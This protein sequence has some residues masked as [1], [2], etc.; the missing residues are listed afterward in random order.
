VETWRLLFFRGGFEMLDSRDFGILGLLAG[1]AGIVVSIFAYKRLE[2]IG[3]KV[4]MSIKDLSAK[5]TVDIGNA[6]VDKAVQKA[7]NR[8]VGLAVASAANKAARTVAD[9]MESKIRKQ[10][11]AS[12][13][14]IERSVSKEI[15]RQVEN[16]NIDKIKR[17]VTEKAKE[18]V[19]EKLD[20]S[21]DD[22]VDGF[23]ENL[24]T[25]SKI[26]KAIGNSVLKTQDREIVIKLE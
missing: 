24:E 11:N 22:L 17:D 10:V 19:L 25:I 15:S 1:A 8:E 2:D 6:V 3:D 14:D 13:S 7:V 12:Y 26:Y 4:D 18:A 5:T 21:L 16:L 20:G 23:S 9:D